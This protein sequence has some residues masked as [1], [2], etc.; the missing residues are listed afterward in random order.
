MFHL[1]VMSKSFG[2]IYRFGV[3]AMYPRVSIYLN[4]MVV[5]LYISSRIGLHNNH[6]HGSIYKLARA[7]TQVK[8]F[9]NSSSNQ[10]SG[11]GEAAIDLLECWV[12]SMSYG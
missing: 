12:Y 3:K 6:H 7:W 10:L 9:L 1:E 2:P 8:P 11:G 4:G 5:M